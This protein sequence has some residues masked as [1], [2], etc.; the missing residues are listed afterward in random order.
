[1]KEKQCTCGCRRSLN[2]LYVCA[3]M[4]HRDR[5]YGAMAAFL[6]TVQL[7]L[8][9]RGLQWSLKPQRIVVQP[10]MEIPFRSTAHHLNSSGGHDQAFLVDKTSM[11]CALSYP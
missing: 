8:I 4:S 9:R 2:Q 3:A 5:F 7:D 6:P 11:D 10:T 1:M